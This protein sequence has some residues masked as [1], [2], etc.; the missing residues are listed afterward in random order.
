MDATSQ[1]TLWVF[2]ALVI[3]I[4]I[5]I[6]AGVPGKMATALDA[7]ANRIRKELD[8]ARTLREEAQHLLAEY[9]RKRRQA[10]QEAADIV[11]AAKREADQIVVDAKTRTEDFVSRRTAA[12]EA[13]IAQAERDAVAEVRSSAVDI[14]VSAARKLMESK[15][16][17]KS[18]AEMFK[19]SLDE[20]KA[21]LN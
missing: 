2:L 16:D 13:K 15:A 14:A 18:G 7:R 21:R 6:W 8:E 3:F 9:Q 10:E 12:A 19:S 20:L 11:E 4:G 5:L 17:A 1:A